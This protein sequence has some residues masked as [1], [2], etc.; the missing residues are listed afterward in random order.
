MDFKRV[1]I[2]LLIFKDL[3]LIKKILQLKPT[4]ETAEGKQGFNFSFFLNK[5]SAYSVLFNILT[6]FY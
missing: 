3:P 2:H 6:F 4:D 1:Q 5:I